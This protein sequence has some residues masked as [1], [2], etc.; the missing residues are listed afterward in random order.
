MGCI[1]HTLLCHHIWYFLMAYSCSV[2][3][4]FV[5]SYQFIKYVCV[6]PVT[7]NMKSL[8]IQTFSQNYMN[9][10]VLLTCIAQSIYVRTLKSSCVSSYTPIPLQ[11]EC[12][13]NPQCRPHFPNRKGSWW[14]LQNS[15]CIPT[16]L[17]HVPGNRQCPWKCSGRQLRVGEIFHFFQNW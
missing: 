15:P 3:K 10:E 2:R 1:H 7:C 13:T 5:P 16:R 4:L 11:Q 8:F 9:S 6:L 17:V 14:C 12:T